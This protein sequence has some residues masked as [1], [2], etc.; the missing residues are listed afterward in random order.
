MRS[1]KDP[2]DYLIEVLHKS[3]RCPSAAFPIPARRGLSFF[4]SGW[5]K[6]EIPRRH[7]I[8]EESLRRAS[9][10]ETGLTFPDFRSSMRLTI[11][12]SQAACTDSSS[13][14]SRLSIREPASSARSATERLSAFLR[15]SDASWLILGII[16]RKHD[17]ADRVVEAVV[18]IHHSLR[19]NHRICSGKRRARP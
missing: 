6:I 1:F 3:F 19:E 17:D 11:S 2:I 12:A 14:S 5:M 15:R 10:R 7:S 4:N 8:A 13:A 18:E 16:Y 9:S